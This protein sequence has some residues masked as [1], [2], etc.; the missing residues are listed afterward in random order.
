LSSRAPPCFGKHVKPLVQAVFAVVS[1][2]QSA[3][4]PRGGLWLVLLVGG[5]SSGDINRLMMIIQGLTASLLEIGC[6]QTAMG[7]PPVTSAVFLIAKS[8]W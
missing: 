1:T 8:F 3:L 4:G 2:H 7:L 5:P 6:N